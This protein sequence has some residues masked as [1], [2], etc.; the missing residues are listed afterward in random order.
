M[1]PAQKR[2][3]GAA[4]SAYAHRYVAAGPGSLSI[5]RLLGAR[6][7]VH[8][9]DRIPQGARRLHSYRIYD[10]VFIFMN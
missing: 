5:L 7:A 3:G 4:P 6:H 8:V 9:A 10:P 1:V 2:Y